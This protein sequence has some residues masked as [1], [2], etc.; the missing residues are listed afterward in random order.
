MRTDT[1]PFLINE[2]CLMKTMSSTNFV[3]QH[4][5]ASLST[6]L[7]F[8]CVNI[9][10]ASPVSDLSSP[11]QATRDA[12]AAILRSSY[13]PPSRTN[14]DPLI[15]SLK[16]GSSKTN[17]MARLQALN[18]HSAGGVGSGNTETEFFPLD[19]FWSLECSFTNTASGSGLARVGLFG[20]LRQISTAPPANFP[21]HWTDYYV[22]G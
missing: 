18:L 19:D 6:F 8:I 3:A 14:W 12:A 22:N 10:L 15:N 2:L 17:V 16:V 11:S 13:F 4:S 20:Q 1:C 5:T 7:F 21:G 9:L